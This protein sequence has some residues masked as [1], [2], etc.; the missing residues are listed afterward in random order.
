MENEDMENRLI[1]QRSFIFGMVAILA[2][3]A[4]VLV[5]P[6]TQTILLAVALVI[7]LKPVYSWLLR[8]KW[9]KDSEN[10]AAGV[11][12]IIFLLVIAILFPVKTSSIMFYSRNQ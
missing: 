11:T 5:W 10:R 9:I 8:K 7:I 3:L 6:F 2:L 12:L 1:Q 4:L